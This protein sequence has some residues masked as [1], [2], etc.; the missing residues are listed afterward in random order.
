MTLLTVTEYLCHRSLRICSFV[1]TIPS[2]LLSSTPV[3]FILSNC[4]S[5]RFIYVVFPCS[6]V[7]YDVRAKTMF[8]PSSL[9]FVLYWVHVWIMLLV[10]IYEY[11]GIIW[12][13]YHI[14]FVSYNSRWQLSL[15]DVCLF[16]LFLRPLY[17]LYF[18][19]LRLIIIL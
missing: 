13:I 3:H 5:S 14:V 18:F 16:P 17:C 9:P 8:G 4:V 6:D 11:L 1:I 10:C 15:V 7:R 2:V 12:F 19:Y